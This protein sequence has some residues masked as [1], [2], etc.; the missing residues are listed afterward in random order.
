MRGNKDD[1][2]VQGFADEWS[3]FPQDKLDPAELRNLFDR[4]F[5]VFPWDGLPPNAVGF[6]L[7]C[8]TGR[9]ARL[10]A[11]R[12]GKLH[13]VDASAEVLAVARRNL[14][15]LDNCVFHQASV[16]RIPLEDS[17]MDFG[18][19]L[20]VLHHVPDTPAAIRSCAAKL[21][22]GAPLLLYLYY[23][24]DNRPRW[25][26][27][28]WRLSDALRRGVSRAPRPLR[29]AAADLLAALAYY[30]LARGALAAERLGLPVGSWPLSLYR[31]QSFYT[32]RTDAL[33]RIGT[34]LEKRFTAAEIQAMMEAAGLE[35][36]AFSAGMPY[37]VA[38]GFKR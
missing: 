17:S 19:C 9:W 34:R 33:D 1:G 28:L 13:C 3:R 12:V 29:F 16:E 6:D 24:L 4:Y 25:Y 2:T 26:R 31:R 32:M 15:G 37:W 22:P 7:G 38:V 8:G 36:I 23:A 21:K 10:A 20:G 11:P 14:R 5:A 18:Y 30:P 35:R 27:L